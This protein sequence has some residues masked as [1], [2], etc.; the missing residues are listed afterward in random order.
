MNCALYFAFLTTFSSA[1]TT[2]DPFG[3]AIFLSLFLLSMICWIVLVHKIWLTSKVGK[4]A[5]QIEKFIVSNKEPLLSLNLQIDRRIKQH[6]F[7]QIF[8]I[9]KQKAVAMLDKNLYFLRKQ[10]ENAEE[11]FL[12]RTDIEILEAHVLTT[13]SYQVK[14]LEK[15]MFILT[16]IVTLAPFLGLLGTV[17]GM[18]LTFGELQRGGTITSNSGVLGGLSTA[19]VTTVLG[20]I[21]AIPALI[22]HNYLKTKVRLLT[23]DMRD[24]LAE[25]ISKLELQYRRVET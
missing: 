13:I 25:L 10:Q 12:S 9:F 19:L 23:S 11:I 24:F 3:R 15:N 2:A 8:F 20:L 22:A 4:N 1:Y 17:W 14:Q 7:L 5:A 16:T 21:I 6:P 18:L